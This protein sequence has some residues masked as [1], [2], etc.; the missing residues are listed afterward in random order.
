LKTFSW[1]L[2]ATCWYFLL[3]KS[4]SFHLLNSRNAKKVKEKRNKSDF[5]LA[6]FLCV[7]WNVCIF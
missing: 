5:E 1:L 7:G 2:F 3:K 6:A 4:L